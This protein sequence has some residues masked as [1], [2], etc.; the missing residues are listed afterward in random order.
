MTNLDFARK[1]TRFINGW[2]NSN[3]WSG[4]EGSSRSGET[5]EANAARDCFEE[6]S[7]LLFQSEFQQGTS[8]LKKTIF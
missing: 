3:L 5:A 1:G 6:L 8:Q 7:G 2:S 4:F